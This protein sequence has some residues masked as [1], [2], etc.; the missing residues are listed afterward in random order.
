MATT[1][2]TTE[3]D[4][5][6]EETVYVRYDALMKEVTN[7]EGYIDEQIAD[8]MFIKLKDKDNKK[9]LQ[10]KIGAKLESLHQI[11]TCL[12]TLKE[13]MNSIIKHISGIH[14]YSCTL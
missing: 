8:I 9:M 4:N 13:S 10:E 5:S 12:T 2:A 1:S 7:Q 14:M 11:E 6:S 3:V